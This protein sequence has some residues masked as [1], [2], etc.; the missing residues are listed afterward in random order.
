MKV[1]FLAVACFCFQA[2]ANE[3]TTHITDIHNNNEKTLQ[4]EFITDN[5]WP[6]FLMPDALTCPVEKKTRYKTRYK[7]HYESQ[8]IELSSQLSDSPGSEPG[9]ALSEPCPVDQEPEV[10]FGQFVEEPNFPDSFKIEFAGAAEMFTPAQVEPEAQLD[11]H[12]GAELRIFHWHLSADWFGEPDASVRIEHIS[13]DLFQ[14]LENH[15]LNPNVFIFTGGYVLDPEPMRVLCKKILTRF[16]L[17]SPE[18]PHDCLEIQQPGYYQEANNAFIISLLPME[19]LSITGDHSTPLGLHKECCT[20]T[21][22][23]IYPFFAFRLYKIHFG[24]RYLKLFV[25]STLDEILWAKKGA[26]WDKPWEYCLEQ[27]KSMLHDTLDDNEIMAM[28]SH[29][30]PESRR[31]P[32]LIKK[33][34]PAIVRQKGVE[35]DVLNNLKAQYYEENRRGVHLSKKASRVSVYSKVPEFRKTLKYKARFQTFYELRSETSTAEIYYPYFGGLLKLFFDNTV[36]DYTPMYPS[37]TTLSFKRRNLKKTDQTDQTG[38][39]GK[40]QPLR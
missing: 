10:Y 13:R 5:K 34:K 6:L 8:T 36:Y 9:I 17:Q 33:L 4:S 2:L 23:D 26:Q 32:S 22:K 37:F 29:H 14:H 35:F 27:V 16:D 11:E 28:V 24:N 18:H 12:A 19:L 3:D 21:Y 40:K 7:T 31:W 39:N 30:L 15:R 38:C 25:T 20:V 1:I